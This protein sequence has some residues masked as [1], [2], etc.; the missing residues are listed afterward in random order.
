MTPRLTIEP[1]AEAE[2]EEAADRYEESVPGLGLEF[3]AE[4]RERTRTILATPQRFPAFGGVKGVQCSHAAGRFPH[5]VVYMVAA[6][7]V[8]VLAYMHPRRRPGYWARRVGAR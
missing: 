1:E 3:L 8:H 2:L 6:D 4:M 7:A 5:L